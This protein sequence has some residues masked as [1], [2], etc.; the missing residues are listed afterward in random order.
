MSNNRKIF[1]TSCVLSLGAVGL[2]LFAAVFWGGELPAGVLRL[3]LALLSAT[4][5]AYGY[6]FTASLPAIS[7][8]LWCRPV[9]GAVCVWLG[10]LAIYIPIQFVISALLIGIGT[11]LV[12]VSACA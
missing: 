6:G 4:A 11:R 8:L 9:R 2:G 3:T 7:P 5:L 10:V 1:M 12:W